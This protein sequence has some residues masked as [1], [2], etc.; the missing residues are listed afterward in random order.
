MSCGAPEIPQHWMREQQDRRRWKAWFD[1]SRLHGLQA[2]GLC[3]SLRDVVVSWQLFE[4]PK[5][6]VEEGPSSDDMRQ[7]GGQERS[8]E[9]IRPIWMEQPC[10]GARCELLQGTRRRGLPETPI[11]PQLRHPEQ[12]YEITSPTRLGGI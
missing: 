3:S 7:T 4:V 11:S 8:S 6:H 12:T 9:G 5:P 1:P 10:C 2:A